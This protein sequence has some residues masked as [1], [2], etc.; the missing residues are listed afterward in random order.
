MLS[1]LLTQN[2]LN[3][4]LYPSQETGDFFLRHGLDVSPQE[5]SQDVRFGLGADGIGF[6]GGM[7]SSE[8][9]SIFYQHAP[10]I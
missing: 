6:P 8:D 7:G 2:F 1:G 9:L 5:L 3:E 4:S 10:S